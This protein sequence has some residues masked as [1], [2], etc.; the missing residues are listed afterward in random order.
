[1]RLFSASN[2]SCA[3]KMLVAILWKLKARH[4]R[5][6]DAITMIAMPITLL[7]EEFMLLTEQDEVFPIGVV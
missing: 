7:V 5:S 1:M 6:H 3:L 2:D 4:G